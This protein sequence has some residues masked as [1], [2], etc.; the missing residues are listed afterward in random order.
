MGKILISADSACDLFP[1]LF[2]QFGIHIVPLSIHMEGNS[3]LD[4][5][6][7]K[8]DDIYASVL[9]CKKIPT[10]SAPAPG[11]FY[12]AW[13]TYLQRGYEVVHL[14]MNSKFSCSYQNA[15]IA[16]QEMPGVS[17]VDTKS[18]STAMGLLILQAARMRDEGASAQEIVQGIRNMRHRLRTEFL[19]DTLEYAHR[20]GRCS[21]LQMFGANLLRL[22]PCLKI[23][24]RGELAVSKKIR[25]SF[26]S[27]AMEYTKYM[28]DFPE[29]DKKRA[30][31]SH[32]GVSGPLLE[33]VVE[34]VKSCGKF[35]E[36]LVTRSGCTISC[37]GGPNTLAIFYMTTES[38]V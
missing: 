36:V 23:D 4:G 30:F 11:A 27:A 3:Y 2:L 8:P 29:I 33:R 19:L 7:I 26:S 37:H 15:R 18:I 20:G 9:R 16:A 14:S 25:G 38:N 28:L 10:T 34:Q 6:E 31:V 21:V 32:T 24:Q 12:M 22:H 1:D 13:E 5:V 35:E 17:V